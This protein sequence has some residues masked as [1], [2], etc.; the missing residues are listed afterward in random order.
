MFTEIQEKG[1]LGDWPERFIVAHSHGGNASI[2]LMRLFGD[3]SDQ[4]FLGVV[5]INT[6]FLSSVVPS[7]GWINKGAG[8][9]WTFIGLLIL[10]YWLFPQYLTGWRA[11]F[12]VALALATEAIENTAA[13][14]WF[15]R[16][17]KARYW[18]MPNI[19]PGIKQKVPVLAVTCR[20]DEAYI[21]LRFLSRTQKHIRFLRE[22]T[23]TPKQ[24]MRPIVPWALKLEIFFF[25]P[26][27]PV[28]SAVSLLLALITKLAFGQTMG[29]GM[30]LDLRVTRD[31]P[32]DF[33]H[34]ELKFFPPKNSLLRHC[35]VYQ[36]PEAIDYIADWIRAKRA[37]GHHPYVRDT[38]YSPPALNAAR[39]S[40]RV[41][42]TDHPFARLFDKAWEHFIARDPRPLRPT[43]PTDGI[44]GSTQV[45][46]SLERAYVKLQSSGLKIF[47]MF[48]RGTLTW[49]AREAP[50]AGGILTSISARVALFQLWREKGQIP[51]QMQWFIVVDERTLCS[52]GLD[53][54]LPFARW[55][56]PSLGRLTIISESAWREILEGP[57]GS[58]YEPRFMYPDHATQDA[59]LLSAA[60]M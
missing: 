58:D 7:G 46:I 57:T 11:L 4:A 26:L 5:T 27:R 49:L 2:G 37:E 60:A 21:L 52:E 55:E 20:A 31:A 28:L 13:V 41:P 35:G 59:T 33:E 32:S 24:M 8:R 51:G 30:K 54:L 50:M 17:I 23:L 36:N 29:T 9:N 14:S 15:D 3:L 1:L 40:T 45:E 47:M 43:E 53:P 6:P 22:Q 16:A 38:T 10:G 39:L 12:G 34:R 25:N 56:K 19:A 48:D 18:D 42:P 44:E